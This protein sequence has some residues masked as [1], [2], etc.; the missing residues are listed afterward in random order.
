MNAT[1]PSLHRATL[2]R[3]NLPRFRSAQGTHD[4]PR[5]RFHPLR[6]LRALRRT[7]WIALFLPFAMIIQSVLLLLP[8]REKARFAAFFWASVSRMLGL[9]VRV[10]GAPARQGTRGPKRPVIYVCNHSSWLDI[11]AIGGQITGCFVAKD[12]VAGWPIIS[13]IARLGRTVFV[14][15]HR[16][17]TL[18]ERDQMRDVLAA[19]DD[20]ILFPEGTSSDGSRV[21]PFR[22]SFLAAAYADAKPLIQP[23]SVVYD[24]LAGLPVGHASRDVFAWYGDMTLAPHFWQVAQYRGKRV[25][26]LFH[27]PMDPADYADRKALAQAIW[28]VVADGAAALRQNR[29]ARPLP[30]IRPA[31]IQEPAFA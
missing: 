17:R 14:S 21:L 16:G 9:S 26:L 5:P 27:T 12:D 24:R 28:Q 18:H 8:G 11:A 7:L 31:A 29:P 2:N 22:S 4:A 23:V 13:T 30:E 10:I 20:L 1:Q 3:G 25:T 6:H 15:R 19:G